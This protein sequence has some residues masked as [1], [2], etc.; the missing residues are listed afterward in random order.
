MNRFKWS[1]SIASLCIRRTASVEADDFKGVH[2]TA[3]L[4]VQ[5]DAT[6]LGLHALLLLTDARAPPTS[7]WTECKS[8][9]AILP[10]LQPSD[11]DGATRSDD[12]D[13][14]NVLFVIN[15]TGSRT[16]Q[17]VR[18]GD[19][20]IVTDRSHANRLYSKIFKREKRG[21]TDHNFVSKRARE[22]RMALSCLHVSMNSD[23]VMKPSRFESIRCNKAERLKYR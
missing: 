14:S 16:I 10:A 19:F 2:T 5:N 11:D 13:D 22:L 6:G 20:F 9:C 7:E 21:G 1:Y 17:W 15:S 8:T 4:P 3:Y 18:I 12:D 23:R